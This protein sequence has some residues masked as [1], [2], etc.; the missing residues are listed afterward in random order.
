MNKGKIEAI[1]EKNFVGKSH[2]RKGFMQPCLFT[3]RVPAN[4]TTF[5]K[6]SL[7]SAMLSLFLRTS[8]FRNAVFQKVL[9]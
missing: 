4:D 6:T 5:I 8:R 9:D 2:V 7:K 1:R 3:E